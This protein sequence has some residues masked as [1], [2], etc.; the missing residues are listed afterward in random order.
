MLGERKDRRSRNSKRPASARGASP[1]ER[2]GHGRVVLHLLILAAVSL[3]LYADALRNGFVTDDTLQLQGNPLVTSYQYIPKLF[4]TNIWSFLHP[5]ISNYYRP[6]HMLFYMGEY[7]LFGFRPLP[8][9]LVNLLLNTAAIFAAYFLVRALA[10]EALA[11]W[12]SLLFTF[13]PI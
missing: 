4:V 5:A 9:H 7:Y 6:L 13:Q 11:L 1:S 10:D 12:A 2:Q 8:F 3:A